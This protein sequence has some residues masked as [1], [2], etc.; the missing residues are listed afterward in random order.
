MVAEEALRGALLTFLVTC[1]WLGHRA[2]VDTD[3]LLLALTA[4][5]GEI[6]EE[7]G[8]GLGRIGGTGV[9]G[10]GVCASTVSRTAR[11]RCSRSARSLSRSHRSA[12]KWSSSSSARHNPCSGPADRRCSSRSHRALLRGASRARGARSDTSRPHKS[13]P[14]SSWTGPE[15]H[16]AERKVGRASSRPPG[17]RGSR[18]PLRCEHARPALAADLA[19]QSSGRSGASSGSPSVSTSSSTGAWRR[20]RACNWASCSPKAVPAACNSSSRT[21]RRQFRRSQGGSGARRSRC[22]VRQAFPRPRASHR[23]RGSLV[24]MGWARAAPATQASS[25]SREPRSPSRS[26]SRGPGAGRSTRRP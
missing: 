10:T 3:R 9:G 17:Q 22:R 2:G 12:S 6:V 19:A 7:T 8:T 23:A 14:A 4:A 15:G 11:T 24:T 26:F 5:A 25:C 21:L 18:R 13:N 20:S 16:R 1:P